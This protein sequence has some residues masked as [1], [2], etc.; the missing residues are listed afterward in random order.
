MADPTFTLQTIIDG[1]RNC[2]I[3][4]TFV[5]AGA[6]QA[7]VVMVDVSS[8][9]PPAGLQLKVKRVSYSIYPQGQVRLQWDSAPDP[10]DMLVLDGADHVKMRQFGGVWNNGGQFA[11]GDILISTQGFT[12]GSSY[13]VILEMVKGVTGQSV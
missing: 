12:I 9:N 10:V 6:D 5:S 11:T 13:T 8:L 4:A 2:V 1:P 7:P 3:K